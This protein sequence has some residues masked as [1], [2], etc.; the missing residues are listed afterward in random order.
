MLRLPRHLHLTLRTC[1]TCQNLYLTLRKCCA[2]HGIQ[3]LRN[4]RAAVPMGPRCERD[5]TM[6]RP[7][8][9]NRLAFSS[10]DM[11]IHAQ[12]YS[13]TA[14]A[15]SFSRALIPSLVICLR[16]SWLSIS[17]RNTEVPSKLP[18]TIYTYTHIMRS[19]L[20]IDGKAWPYTSRLNSDADSRF[21]PCAGSCGEREKERKKDRQTDRKK[22][23]KK[24]GKKE[25]KKEKEEE[26]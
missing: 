23:R 25:R 13:P 10:P 14:R 24:E 6:V 21:V 15:R 4:L 22:E 9:P 16:E 2:C 8:A 18:L 7:G 3:S 26:R 19:S 11:Q 1:C 20:T 5:P 12:F 17:C